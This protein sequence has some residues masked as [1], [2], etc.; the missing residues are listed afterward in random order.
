MDSRAGYI[1]NA[2]GMANSMQYLRVTDG[3]SMLSTFYPG[4]AHSKLT[5]HIILRGEMTLTA[6]GRT[7]TYRAGQRCD[8]PAGALHS[9]KMG[10]TG[11]RYLIGE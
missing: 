2:L 10:P 9:A 4:H 8:V 6:N 5:A 3:K 1:Q 11:C 7:E